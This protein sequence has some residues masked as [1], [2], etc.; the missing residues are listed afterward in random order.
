MQNSTPSPHTYTLKSFFSKTG[1]HNLSKCYF[2]EKESS[3][4]RI[5]TPGPGTYDANS[6]VDNKY[7]KKFSIYPKINYPGIEICAF[8]SSFL[9]AYN[10][11]ILENKEKIRNPGPNS[12]RPD[13]KL[14]ENTKFT[15]ISFGLGNRQFL[16][17]CESI[18][19]G[20]AC[21]S[22]KSKF[23]P[24]KISSTRSTIKK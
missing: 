23:T 5:V 6:F 20:P 8:P 4:S 12:Y 17:K 1:T 15:Q 2:G 16:S 13:S 19:P 3:P 11:V 21:Y 24:D 22:I 7:S 14:C 9:S 10:F 18:S